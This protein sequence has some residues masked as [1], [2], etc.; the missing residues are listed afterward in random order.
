MARLTAFALIATAAIASLAP[1]QSEA[2]AAAV[3]GAVAFC[4]S[5]MVVLGIDSTPSGSGYTYRVTLRNRSEF[6]VRYTAT[7]KAGATVMVSAAL[8]QT[9]QISPGVTQQITLGSGSDPNINGGTVAVSHD[10]MSDRVPSLSLTDCRFSR[11]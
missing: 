7:F 5:S 9:M 10:R 6:L 1:R 4:T 8:G 11:P 3:G 2:A